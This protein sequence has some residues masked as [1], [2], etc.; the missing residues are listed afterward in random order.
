M[1]LAFMFKR[2]HRQ[3]RETRWCRQ[4]HIP[5]WTNVSRRNALKI[6]RTS[7]VSWAFCTHSISFN[8]HKLSFIA[9]FWQQRKLQ[10][11]EFS[12]LDLSLKDTKV[13]TCTKAFAS[14]LLG[15][16]PCHDPEPPL[17][18]S[19]CLC[20][21]FRRPLTLLLSVLYESVPSIHQASQSPFLCFFLCSAF[22]AHTTTWHTLYLL[23]QFIYC[24]SLSPP[25]PKSYLPWWQGM[26]GPYSL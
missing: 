21:D 11:R 25:E 3:G 15:V 7:T 14:P 1:T 10:L 18:Q 20:S 12:D 22:K 5:T 4:A 26:C 6:H 23:V 9:V 2:H 24:I 13:A 8:P 19:P 16:T 17:F